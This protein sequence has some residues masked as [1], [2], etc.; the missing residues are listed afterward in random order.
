MSQ[1]TKEEVL[2]LSKLAR[3]RLTDEEVEKYTIELG[4]ILNYVELLSAIDT[5][6]LSATNQVTGL[7]NVYRPDTVQ[8]YTAKP[9]DLLDATPANKDG[10]IQVK[11]MI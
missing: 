10:Y 5:D 2:K 1:L 9:K 6:G 3:L 11:R 8:E 4:E 7:Q